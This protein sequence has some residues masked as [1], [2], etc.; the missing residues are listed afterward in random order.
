MAWV[1]DIDGVVWLAGMPIP[2][3]AEAIASLRDAGRRILLLS[4]NSGP[5]V[6][7]YLQLLADAGVELSPDELV[8]SSQAAASML[9]PGSTAAYVGGPGIAEALGER[10]VEVVAMTEGPDAVVVGRDVEL[11]HDLLAAAATA[12][13]NGARF[14]ATNL[15]PT[16]P[17]GG[18]LL[19]G[20]GAVV[21]FVATA[22]GRAPEVAGKP[23][24]PVAEL[25][26]R[27]CGVP[28]VMIGDRAD[29]DGEFARAVGAPFV[30]VL[31]GSTKA[32]DLP[33]RPE[34][35]LAVADLAAAVAELLADAGRSTTVGS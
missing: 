24:P 9:D 14:V 4:N 21:A 18:G 20:A 1:I 27:R 26:R 31:S 35:V 25:V 5:T 32:E 29:T 17:T 3:A 19:P 23:H 22:A 7:D 12:V 33:V 28:E 30:L 2:G 16:Y 15:D 13:R 10:G 34:P 11:D 8:T 6:A